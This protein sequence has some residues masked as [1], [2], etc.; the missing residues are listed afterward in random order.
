[1]LYEYLAAVHEDAPLRRL[2]QLVRRLQAAGCE[3]QWDRAASQLRL[4]VRDNEGAW[5]QTALV[6]MLLLAFKDVVGWSGH[7]TRVDDTRA[8]LQL[9]TGRDE[10]VSA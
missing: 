10:T 1:M 2:R 7:S 8:V 9:T 6:T 4:R 5:M 3:V